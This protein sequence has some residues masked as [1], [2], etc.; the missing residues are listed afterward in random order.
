MAE[1]TV[2]GFEIV[3]ATTAAVSAVINTIADNQHVQMFA[4]GGANEQ[5]ICICWYA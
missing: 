1:F 5:Q 2:T 3:D 4:I